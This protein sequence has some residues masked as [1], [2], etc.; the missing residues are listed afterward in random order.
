M[1]RRKVERLVRAAPLGGSNGIAFGPDGRLYVA[2]YLAGQI[3][4][5]DL[6]TG[7]VEVVV[8][9]DGP[10]RSPDDL[11][12][13]T[14]GA[15]YVTDLIPGRV[16]RRDPAGTFTLVT[17]RI[18][19]PNGIACV[20]TRVFANEMIPGGRLLELSPAGDEPRVLAAG[21]AMGNA[22]QLGPDGR[23]YYPHMLTGEVFR[24]PLD[25]GEPELVAADVPAPVAVRFDREGVLLVLS[26]GQTGTVTR[27]D[28][29]G[30]GDRSAV[31]SDLNALDNAAFDADN[32]MY[33]SSYA[34]GGIAELAPDGRTRQIVPRGL[35]GP[36]GVTIDLGGGIH[37]ADHYRLAQ[38]GNG[39]DED[40]T[41]TDLLTFVHGVA[42]DGDLLHAT[43]QYGQV[44]TY[45]R[46]SGTVRTRADGLNRPLG[47]AVRADGTLVVA[48]SGAGRVLTIDHDDQI[49][50]LA[51]GLGRPVGVA[52]GADQRCYV[53]DEQ[54]GAVHRIED[55][56]PALLAGG[57]G[58]PQGITVHDGTL[59]I[60]EPSHR[61]LL[62]I[63]LA[64]GDV[65][66]EADSLAVAPATGLTD[67]D[68]D[69]SL[70]EPTPS[71]PDT[72]PSHPRTGPSRPERS[73]FVIPGL[74][75][76]PRPFAGIA[77]TPNGALVIAANGDGSVLH[78]PAPAP[79]PPPSPPDPQGAQRTPPRPLRQPPRRTFHVT[80]AR[81]PLRAPVSPDRRSHP[82]NPR[83]SPIPRESASSYP[84]PMELAE[85]RTYP[86]KSTKAVPRPS[87]Q[88]LPWG[89]EGDRRW[90][91]VDPRGE[92]I[93]VGEHPRLLSVSAAETADGHLLLSADGMDD[94][95][96][97][98]PTGDTLP[99][100]FANF[101]RGVLAHPDAHDWFTRL[102]GKPA[103]L[104]RQEDP[105]PATPGGPPEETVPFAWDAAL[106]LVSRSSLSRL[107]DWITEGAAER[108]EH[109][110]EPLDITRFRPNAIIDGAPPFVEDT[111]TSVRIG[112]IDFRVS[113]LCDRCAATTWDPATLDRGKEPLRTLAKHRR[114][115]G[116]TWFG[117]RLVPKN[118]GELRVGDEVRPG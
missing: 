34:H 21:L 25:G 10:L 24:V 90:A 30:T 92:L 2:Q 117:I 83:T 70:P 64:T 20:G 9:P 28:L 16:W 100:S 79:R 106:H 8:P 3:S 65:R 94:L 6:A 113:E 39:P 114:W 66:T 27:L 107:N 82:R 93:W 37:L 41:T 15:M 78:L 45:D 33:V 43:S 105:R 14:A 73:L 55:G 68:H 5:V 80:T 59:Y 56:G 22:M 75:G 18:T 19:A 109:P 96:V 84:C 31:V 47:V 11:A 61:R 1:S 7:D 76:I 101:T 54:L 4:A 52:V 53:S 32:R 95:K 77:A 74:P 91:V 26:L 102:L 110:P 98:P 48:E 118:L 42:A 86:V 50:V 69:P 87:A 63:D 85:I 60:V 51:G 103:R 49:S 99:V 71:H 88:V 17:D 62:A 112:E 57:L 38:P 12:F 29:T 104:V 35:G 13:D 97:P 81:L 108:Q 67:P 46:R 44:R 36:F 72:G 58:T 115:D 111:W 116:N 40:V 89:L 23:L